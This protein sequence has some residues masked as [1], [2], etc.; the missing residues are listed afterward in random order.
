[1]EDVSD[2]EGFSVFFMWMVRSDVRYEERK[3]MAGDIGRGDAFGSDRQCPDG[4][5]RRLW[6]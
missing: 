3:K 6:P 1:M 4:N 5:S 2:D